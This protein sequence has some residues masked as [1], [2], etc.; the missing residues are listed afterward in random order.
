MTKTFLWYDLETW[1]LDAAGSGIVSFACQ[2]TN[3]NLEPVA[4]PI[5]LMC[6]PPEDCL[7][8]P[9]AMLVHGISPLQANK[10]GLTEY[11]FARRIHEQFNTPDTCIVGFNNL[12][13]DDE[14]CRYL[15]YRNLLDPYSHQWRY[16]NSRWDVLDMFRVCHACKP[17]TLRWH[18]NDQ[19][20]TSFT[21]QNMAQANDI[22]VDQAHDALSDVTTTIALANMVRQRQPEMFEYLFAIR[23]KKEV[24]KFLDARRDKPFIHVS[25]MFPAKHGR[26]SLVLP[27]AYDREQRQ[28]LHV[29]DLHSDISALLSLSA[30][31]LREILFTPRNQLPEDVVP[32]ML[33]TLHIN[34]C[35]V[36]L[37]AKMLTEEMA[38]RLDI[39]INLCYKNYQLIEAD[40]QHLA[41]KVQEVFADAPEHPANRDVN[42]QLYDNLFSDKDRL[43]MD[44][45]HT[46]PISDWH[47]IQ[48]D[49]DD[50]RLSQLW[51]RLQGRCQEEQL[52]S[53]AREQWH[54][55]LMRLYQGQVDRVTG[56]I[57]RLEVIADMRSNT[58][59]S[60]RDSGLLDD[61]RAYIEGKA[62]LLGL[63]Y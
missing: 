6:R 1:G 61:L 12:R 52:D 49:S 37:P 32:P 3:M 28:K 39:N 18:A 44:R 5:Q 63:G 62:K 46:T 40:K 50:Q 48:L 4:D 43:V 53:T 16:H 58:H 57:P 51:L 54:D 11:E 36:L 26:L 15:F 9:Q 8:E 33:K 19:G 45:V 20:D 41:V 13:F 17:E 29:F 38:N 24:A 47:L 10:E 56:V 21:L 22:A 2:R 14:F 55:Y 23:T 30:G 34:R 59:I 7:P 60:E 31:E 25:P 35:P 27:L 42:R